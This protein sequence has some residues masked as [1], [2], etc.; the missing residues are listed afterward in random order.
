[1]DPITQFSDYLTEYDRIV[2]FTGAGISTA[3]GVPDFRSPNGIWQTY[4]PVYF[5][6]FLANESD[7]RRYWQMK[8]ETYELYKDVVPNPAHDWVYDLEVKR[9]LVGLITQNVDG[10]HRQAGHAEDKM[11][12]IHGTD[13]QVMCLDCE[14]RWEASVFFE[15]LDLSVPLPV[16]DVCG[17]LLKPAT[18]SFGQSMDP[19]TMTIASQWC[20]EAQLFI[21]IGSSLVVHPAASL[22]VLALSYG[23]ILVIL[24]REE[25]PL[26][27]RAHLVIHDDI[28]TVLSSIS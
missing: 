27:D 19:R 8:K 11:V 23:A 18:I 25:T 21:S 17:G 10:L 9:K 15:S 20:F 22:P 13:R 12:E 28:C 26:D 1:M 4:K 14:K 16:C 24:N 7:R 5:N 3:S 6:D 2:V